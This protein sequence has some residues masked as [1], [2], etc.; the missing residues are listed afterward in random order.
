MKRADVETLCEI[1]KADCLSKMF[2]DVCMHR[3][4]QRFSPLL[5]NTVTH[6]SGHTLGLF[7]NV[8]MDGVHHDPIGDTGTGPDNLM[9]WNEQGG[10]TV[11]SGQAFV[12]RRNIMVRQ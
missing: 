9:Y 1:F 8:E 6:E 3:F 7:H 5:G 12:I 11:T 4:G 10:G 2:G